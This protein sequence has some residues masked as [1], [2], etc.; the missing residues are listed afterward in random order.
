MV[1]PKKSLVSSL[2]LLLTLTAV[3]AGSFAFPAAA[4]NDRAA[5][6]AILD[7]IGRKDT[8][9]DE[10]AEF[11]REGRV[12]KLNLN[13]RG[14]SSSP[15]T[16]FPQEIFRLTALRGL[17]LRGNALK[18][19]PPE[20]G[21]LAELMELDLANNNDL[22]TLPPT[23]G[24]LA[25]L[26]RLDVRFCGLSTLPFSFGNLKSLEMLQ[27]WGNEFTEL[28]AAVLEM[29]ALKDLHLNNNRLTTLPVEITK[30][31]N[32]KYIDTQRNTIC[33]VPPQV[34][35][36]LSRLERRWRDYQRCDNVKH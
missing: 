23:I 26:Q 3:L 6:R 17:L 4:Q 1:M 30:L 16:E 29:T 2:T 33:N 10:V 15:I 8:E 28:P 18:A 36:W 7:N 13:R 21:N 20:I 25:N 11:S 19:I 12:I 35:A 5:V 32:L 14:L 24:N 34:D 22:G 31:T 27:L 9:V